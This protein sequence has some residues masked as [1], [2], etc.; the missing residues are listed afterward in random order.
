MSHRIER[1]QRAVLL[2]IATS[3]LA[4][5][6]LAKAL[7]ICHHHRGAELA[8]AF[9]HQHESCRCVPVHC[10]CCDHDVAPDGDPAPHAGE[11]CDCGCDPQADDPV[12]LEPGLPAAQVRA[13]AAL[14]MFAALRV[15]PGQPRSAQTPPTRFATGPPPPRIDTHLQLHATNVLML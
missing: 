11:P 8:F 5:L 2:V 3:L 7:V 14:G 6:A 12:R 10:G 9:G 13:T 15:R 4:L 1:H